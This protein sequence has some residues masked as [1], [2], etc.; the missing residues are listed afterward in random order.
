[1]RNKAN[2][3]L[4]VED[5]IQG[6]DENDGCSAGTLN[7]TFAQIQKSAASKYRRKL[8][9]LAECHHYNTNGI[10]LNYTNVI[11]DDE[12]ALNSIVNNQNYTALYPG[13]YFADLMGQSLSSNPKLTVVETQNYLLTKFET[14]RASYNPELIKEALFVE[15]RSTV[16]AQFEV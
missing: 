7:A 5:L 15:P 2:R 9:L 6:V 13:V 4:S 3:F 14:T 8:P 11:Y 1:M 16:A 10:R 12:C